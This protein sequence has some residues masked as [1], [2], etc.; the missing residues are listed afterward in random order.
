MSCCLAATAYQ[1]Q[2]FFL[3][4]LL[5]LST[6]TIVSFKTKLYLHLLDLYLISL[7]CCVGQDVQHDAEEQQW[8]WTPPLAPDL[9]GKLLASHHSVRC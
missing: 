5:G 1:F 7:S 6:Q 3:V 8:E 4:D 2:D 9:T